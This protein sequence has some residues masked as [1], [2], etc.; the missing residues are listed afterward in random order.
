[1]LVWLACVPID[2][3]LYEQAMKKP[4]FLQAFNTCGMIREESARLDCQVASMERFERLEKSDCDGLPAGIWHEECLFLYAERQSHAGNQ[5]EALY[6]CTLTGFAREC[7]F[8]LIRNGVRQVIQESPEVAAQA[9]TPYQGMP[10]APDAERLFWKTWWRE[11]LVLKKPLT[12]EGCPG[13]ACKAGLQ[14]VLYGLLEVRLRASGGK[15][16]KE[17]SRLEPENTWVAGPEI[18]GWIAQWKQDACLREAQGPLPLP[19]T[20]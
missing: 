2:A 15:F 11:R 6:A 13:A 8:H 14:E 20:P 5:K 3:V 18:D 12:P 16:C 10:F 19:K 1:M 4:D 9:I 17:E 7:S